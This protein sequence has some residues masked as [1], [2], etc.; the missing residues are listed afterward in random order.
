VAAGLVTV[1]VGTETNGSIIC[2]ASINGI[3]GIKPTVG[4][5]SRSGVIP[6]AMSLD[7]PG[8]MAR[9]VADAAAL[10]NI[11]AAYD[12]KDLSTEHSRDRAPVDYTLALNAN[13]L[14]GVRVGVL[15]KVASFHDRV[16]DIFERALQAMRSCGAVI[17]DPVEIAPHGNYGHVSLLMRYEFKDGINRYLAARK[18]PGPKSLVEL[19]AFN[20]NKRELEMPFFGQHHFHEA[21]AQGPLTD[22]A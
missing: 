10:L 22:D 6:L 5:I 11:L 4:L 3:V 19:I 16:D 12:P 15:R 17:V 21:Q 8:P 7:T 18:G 2:P 20:E 1:A 9:T 13:S 14:A